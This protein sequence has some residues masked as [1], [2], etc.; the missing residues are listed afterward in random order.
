MAFWDDITST[1]RKGIAATGGALGKAYDAT[2]GPTGAALRTLP[3]DVIG[4]AGQ[5]YNDAVGGI[6]G[7]YAGA[8]NFLN[9][10]GDTVQYVVRE[11]PAAVRDITTPVGRGAGDLLNGGGDAL[12]GAGKGLASTGQGL[13]LAGLGIG[14]VAVVVVL[15]IIVFAF[16]NPRAVASAGGVRA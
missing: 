13:K 5:G 4:G 9:R 7:A 10:G 12:S 11:V 16:K 14:A 15:A 8:G 6:K 2:L 3:A 1:A